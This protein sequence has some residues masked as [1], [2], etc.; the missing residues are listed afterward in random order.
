MPAKRRRTKGRAS[1]SDSARAIYRERPEAIQGSI[2]LDE[3]LA[4]ALNR[5]QLIA[6]P[7]IGSL[8]EELK[9]NRA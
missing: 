6:Y 5:T 3:E 8:I 4:V 9:E 7:D 2:I 1:V